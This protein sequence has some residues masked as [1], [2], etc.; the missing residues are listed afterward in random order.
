V[1]VT[2]RQSPQ[3]SPFLAHK[4]RNMFG[5]PRQINFGKVGESNDREFLFDVPRQDR[6]KTPKRTVVAVHRLSAPPC[7]LPCESVRIRLAA[8]E[9]DR[10]KDLRPAFSLQECAGSYAALPGQKIV[11]SNQETVTR[12]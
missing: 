4:F 10:S 12:R 3:T 11:E 6:F 5:N 2:T 9:D 7:N 1:F 8:L